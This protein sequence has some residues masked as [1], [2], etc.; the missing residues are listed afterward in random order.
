MRR[1][2][3]GA[4]P[5]YVEPARLEN[6]TAESR[7]G[8]NASTPSLAKELRKLGVGWVRFENFKW[9][10]VS[11]KPHEF[12]FTGGTAPWHLNIDDITREYRDAGLNILPMMFLTPEWASSPGEEVAQGMK[13]SQPPHHDADFGEFAF[14][15]VARFTDKRTSTQV[16]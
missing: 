2:R 5:V 8:L 11:P 6:V 4:K 3:S 12:N 13:L 1:S 14:Q 9:P 15:S 7:F 10:M 16:Y